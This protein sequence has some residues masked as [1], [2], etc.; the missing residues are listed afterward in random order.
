MG[1]KVVRAS[2]YDDATAVPHGE[3][4]DKEGGSTPRDFESAAQR[5]KSG[6]P[7][8]FSRS[9]MGWRRQCPGAVRFSL[10]SGGLGGSAA[11]FYGRS[12]MSKLQGQMRR[13]LFLSMLSTSSRYP[14]TG[15]SPAHRSRENRPGRRKSVGRR[16]SGFGAR[17]CGRRCS[18]P[19]SKHRGNEPACRHLQRPD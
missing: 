18:H 3:G 14:P 17:T 11:A 12:R 5:S 15:A 10:D 8:R 13:H 4:R 16:P 6:R 2:F 9:R 7:R 1:G 19:A